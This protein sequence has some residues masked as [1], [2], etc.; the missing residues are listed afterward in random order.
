MNE[1]SAGADRRNGDDMVIFARVALICCTAVLL[2]LLNIS[3]KKDPFSY[4]NITTISL[5]LLLA[6]IFTESFTMHPVRGADGGVLVVRT[7][8]EFLWQFS[9]KLCVPFCFICIFLCVSN[10]VLLR[11]EGYRRNNF[12]G[13]I[14][15]GLYLT[16]INIMWIP[17]NR[18]PAFLTGPMV[19][20][21]LLFC[22]AECTVLAILVAGYAV[23]KLKPVY[24]RDFII[25]LGC[26]ISKKGKLRPLLKGRADRAIRFAWEQE[27]KTEKS[28]LYV[29]S[30]GKGADE[31]M[32]EGSAMEM[33]LISHGAE[34]YEV[35]AEKESRNTLENLVFSKRIIDGL[36]ENARIAVVTTN[37]HVL[38]SGM[39][40]K[41]AGIDA[42]VIGSKTV[43]YFWPN[44]FFRETVAVLFMFMKV[45]L[46][47]AA[48][49][50][51]AAA[52]V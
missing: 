40:A 14:F 47:A 41:R 29:P 21:R 28:A 4:R 36:R 43:W 16:I 24:D 50:L 34:D 52:M 38:R 6:G 51:A 22:Y 37:F 27:W 31:P 12:L 2:F 10:I 23:L 1:R 45:H 20:L 5:I 46:F 9:I 8:A 48:L 49:F 3:F 18:M 39:L 44:A 11:K 13:F 32:S 19:F 15:S 25:I 17:M 7:G 42:V 35:F 30:G 26:S 33:Y